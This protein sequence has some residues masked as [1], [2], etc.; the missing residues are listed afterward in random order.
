MKHLIVLILLLAAGRADAQEL[1]VFSDPASNVPANVLTAKLGTQWGE[2]RHHYPGNAKRFTPELMLGLNRRFMLRA[3]TTFSNM[4]SEN[5][6]WEA[7]Y[8]YGKYRFLSND[9]VHR[10]FRIA[11][12]AEAA[13]SVNTPYFQ[14]ISLQGDRSGVQAGIIATQLVNKFAASVT[15]SFIQALNEK[16]ELPDQAFN[17]SLSGGLLLLPREYTSY[18]Q[19]N[20]NLYLELLGQ[21]TIDKASY[22]LDLA[23][24]LQFI[25]NSNSKLNFGYRFQLNGNQ[26][27]S[28]ERS[29]M[30]SFEHNFFNVLK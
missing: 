12:F 18:K 6:Q 9:E 10:H 26:F 30:I 13:Y 23:P 8:L 5:T 16:T 1:Y 11:A 14:D 7:A 22:Y 24:A 21:Q 3:G 17:Y 19:L 4:Y 27:R 28:M 20:V 15:T 29:Y 2:E 25:F